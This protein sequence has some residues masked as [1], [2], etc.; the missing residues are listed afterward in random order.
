VSL[1]FALVFLLQAASGSTCADVADCRAQADAAAARGD[2]ETFHDLAWRTVQKGKR[3]DPDLMFLLARAQAMSGRPDDALVMLERIVALGGKP[4]VSTN[5]DFARVRQLARW[6]EVASKFDPGGA[7]GPAA[8]APGV[9]SA[10]PAPAPSASSARSAPAASSSSAPTPA[11]PA[12]AAAPPALS[13]DPPAL[14][15]VAGLAHDTVSR[16]FVLGDRASSRLMIIDEVSHHVVNY[17]SAATA[18]FLDEL[19]GFAVDPRRGDLWVASAKGSGGDATST[20]HKLQLVSGR[21]LMEAPPADGAGA[22]R[23]VDVAIT[24]DGTV[25][26][27]DDVDARLFRVRPGAR[28]L[29]QVLRLQA[30]HPTALTAADDRVLYVAAEDGLV[31]VDLTSNKTANVKSVEKLTGFVSLAWR[32]DSLVGVE[33][34][35]GSYLVVR[36]PLDSS[37]T[38]AQPRAILAASTEP[39]V[40]TLTPEGFYYLSEPGAIR[41]VKLK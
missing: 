21:T 15:A 39:T 31:R 27:I 12:A 4:D 19:T 40:G 3:N 41:L 7:A 14:T 2:Y 26:A 29:E 23:L 8:G 33:R 25:Y 35:A 17:A 24:P 10:P 13:F 22:L 18:G 36:I 11:S 34:V 1:L 20:L 37:G 30:A 32:A 6:P 38:R 5:P 9:P 28:R 16:R